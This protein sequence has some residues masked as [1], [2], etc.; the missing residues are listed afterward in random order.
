MAT[1]YGYVQRDPQD[2]QLNW[3][4]I[5]TD[6]VDMLNNEVKVREEKKLQLIKPLRIIKLFLIMFLKEKILN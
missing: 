4:Q 1:K 6:T 2:T 3:N 5:A